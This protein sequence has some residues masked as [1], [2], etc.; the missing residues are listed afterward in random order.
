MTADELWKRS[1]QKWLED[2]HT[3]MQKLNH[4]RGIGDE[5]TDARHVPLELLDMLPPLLARSDGA[6]R[7]LP[8]T[9]ALLTAPDPT[10][11]FLRKAEMNDLLGQTSGDESPEDFRKLLLDENEKL[12][13]GRVSLPSN[14]DAPLAKGQV[15]SRLYAL[16]S[17]IRGM[18]EQVSAVI[19]FE[20]MEKMIAALDVDGFGQLATAALAEISAMKAAA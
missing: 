18:A 20:H 10:A 9:A 4:A 11:E 13:A 3:A 8:A 14:P 19:D 2:S 7:D 12:T 15:Q 17:K 1:H 16:V 6:L 5:P